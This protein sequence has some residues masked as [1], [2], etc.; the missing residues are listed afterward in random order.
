VTVPGTSLTVGI[1]DG[2]V[3]KTES[4]R[5]YL[6]GWRDIVLLK[7]LDA[8]TRRSS[9]PAQANVVFY[10]ASLPEGVSLEEYRSN[11]SAAH[12]MRN[13][14]ITFK[15][16]GGFVLESHLSK[17]MVLTLNSSLFVYQVRALDDFENY[18]ALWSWLP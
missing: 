5:D 14:D 3:D 8:P 16:Y 17:V 11:L 10:V 15:G 1:P 7:K 9:L 4:Y 2:W 13:Q 18:R 6:D 12:R